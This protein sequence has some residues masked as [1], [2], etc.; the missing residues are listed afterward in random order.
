MNIHDSILFPA[1]EEI[2]ETQG[3]NE[4]LLKSPDTILFGEGALLDSVGLVSFIVTVERTVEEVT[5]KTITLASEKAFSRKQSPFRTVE[6]LA[7][8]IEELLAEE[9]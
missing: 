1:L 9:E 2:N 5:G 6:T 8:Y 3:E 4:Q 7:K